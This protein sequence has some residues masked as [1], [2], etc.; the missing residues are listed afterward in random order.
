MN[1]PNLKEIEIYNNPECLLKNVE[2]DDPSKVPLDYK[3]KF[4]NLTCIGIG[5]DGPIYPGIN[6]KQNHFNEYLKS[7]CPR[8]S[9]EIIF[10]KVPSESDLWSDTS[11]EAAVYRTKNFEKFTAESFY[12]AN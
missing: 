11:R 2:I 12:I 5:F 3:N 8:I 1:C 6:A 7:K 4:L 9:D 10:K